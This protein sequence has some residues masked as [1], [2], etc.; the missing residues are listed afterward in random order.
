MFRRQPRAPAATVL[1]ELGVDRGCRRGATFPGSSDG[2]SANEKGNVLTAAGQPPKCAIMIPQSIRGCRSPGRST[3]YHERLT[4]R[5][6]K[7]SGAARSRRIAG[8]TGETVFIA[9]RR[10]RLDRRQDRAKQ[11]QAI[12]E[13]SNYP[14]SDGPRAAGFECRSGTEPGPTGQTGCTSAAIHYARRRRGT[15]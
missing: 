9:R 2:R 7:S 5:E 11:R 13:I 3:G 12:I 8:A 14:S 1:S 4:I 6:R 10:R 15:T